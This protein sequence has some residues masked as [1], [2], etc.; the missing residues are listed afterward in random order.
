MGRGTPAPHPQG[1]APALS[2]RM[3]TSLQLSQFYIY[4]KLAS[5]CEVEYQLDSQTWQWGENVLHVITQQDSTILCKC[6][7]T[8]PFLTKKTTKF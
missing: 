1:D 4:T 2:H 3:P 6:F 8:C 7:R 5:A